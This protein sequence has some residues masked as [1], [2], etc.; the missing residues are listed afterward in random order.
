MPVPLSRVVDSQYRKKVNFL[1]DKDLITLAKKMIGDKDC[2]FN[3][4]SYDFIKDLSIPADHRD[5]ISIRQRDWLQSVVQANLL[6]KY[7]SFIDSL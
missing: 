1:S 4:K 2:K 6:A 3:T 7:W 5:C